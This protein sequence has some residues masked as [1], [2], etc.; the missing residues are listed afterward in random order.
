MTTMTLS[1]T[2][3][4]ARLAVRLDANEMAAVEQLARREFLT[5]TGLARRIILRECERSGIPPRQHEA[6]EPPTA[7]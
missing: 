3:R 7:A 6:T 1:R 2:W 5:P 4:R